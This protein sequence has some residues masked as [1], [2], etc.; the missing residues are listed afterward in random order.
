MLLSP[1]GSAAYF[2]GP[3]GL[4]LKPKALV[5]PPV[6]QFFALPSNLC[7]RNCFHK[8]ELQ[9]ADDENPS[10]HMRFVSAVLA[11]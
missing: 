11:L 9:P 6:S 7:G 1:P 10:E 3:R 4:L 5:P 2:E 8:L